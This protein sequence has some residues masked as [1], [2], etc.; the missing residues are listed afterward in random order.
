M[1]VT[2]PHGR[3]ELQY[4]VSL[5]TYYM[6]ITLLATRMAAL[7]PNPDDLHVRAYPRAQF[8]AKGGPRIHMRMH[9]GL[10]DDS[11]NVDVTF[12]A[13]YWPTFGW[14]E[15][16]R[17]QGRGSQVNLP[18]YEASEP[19]SPPASPRA[20]QPSTLTAPVCPA[21]HNARTALWNKFD[22]A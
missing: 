9:V 16:Q 5:A 2:R 8:S 3:L 22:E 20:T 19:P 4:S 10:S 14:N 1:S 18:D 17:A 21:R 15:L 11:A 12:S 7:V 6:V 13:S